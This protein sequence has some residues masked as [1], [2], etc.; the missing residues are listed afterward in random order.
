MKTKKKYRKFKWL[1]YSF[2]WIALFT[3]LLTLI[4]V[5]HKEYLTMKSGWS[6]SFGGVLVVLYVVLLL[7]VG[8]PKIHKVAWV[9]MLLVIVVALDK[10]LDNIQ[11]LT[12]MAFI[13]T[14]GYS[15]F[16][17]PAKYFAKRLDTY[18]NEEDRMIAREEITEYREKNRGSV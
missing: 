13:G 9:G 7:K 4:I 17:I 15:I 2:A 14:C 12:L 11:V 3:P 10:V 16:E 8:I 1:F 6:L 5:N 18:V